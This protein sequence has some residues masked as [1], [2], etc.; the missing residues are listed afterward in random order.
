[1][2]KERVCSTR[3]SVDVVLSCAARCL[4]LALTHS[5]FVGYWL[6]IGTMRLR[7]IEQFGII[8]VGEYLLFN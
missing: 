7:S 3:Y 6:A 5:P 1:M 2:L 8:D 4:N